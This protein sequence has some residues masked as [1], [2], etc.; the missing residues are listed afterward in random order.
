VITTGI[1]CT[2]NVLPQA[3]SGKKIKKPAAGTSAHPEGIEIIFNSFRM[4][5]YNFSL[6]PTGSALVYSTYL[7]G[8]GDDS[9]FSIAVD[10]TGH[11]YITGV[12]HSGDFPTTSG[13]F[14]TG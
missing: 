5:S 4:C 6:D 13:A 3:S 9:G 2:G 14:Q 7:G 1:S 12:T 11:A 10:A 8:S